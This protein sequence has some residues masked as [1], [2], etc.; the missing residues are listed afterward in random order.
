MCEKVD[1]GGLRRSEPTPEVEELEQI[2]EGQEEEL[3]A[4][5]VLSGRPP[6]TYQFCSSLVCRLGRFWLIKLMLCARPFDNEGWSYAIVSQICLARMMMKAFDRTSFK[7]HGF[8]QGISYAK[9]H[10]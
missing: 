6:I 2:V 9:P 7:V 1:D 5:D 8:A 10:T 3:S 4:A